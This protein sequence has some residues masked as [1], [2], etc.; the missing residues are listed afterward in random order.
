MAIDDNEI[1]GLTGA[2]VK[3]LPGKLEAIK[4][5]AKL[6]LPAD[7]NAN[8][9]NWDDTNPEHFNCVAFWKLEDGLYEC[10][11][12][13]G[14][15]S[16]YFSRTVSTTNTSHCIAMI[17]RH[18]TSDAQVFLVQGGGYPRYISVNKN[19]GATIKDIFGITTESVKDNLTTRSQNDALSANQG[20]VLKQLIDDL[21]ARVAALE[22]N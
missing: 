14:G 17:D 6:L 16:V 10:D 13:S 15:I 5:K 1:Y 18:S 4:G 2:Q 21:T 11:A 12:G 3:D 20:Y 9:D 7:A 22:G 8:K 19:T